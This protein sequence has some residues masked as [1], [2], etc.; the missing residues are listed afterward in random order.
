MLC[1]LSASKLVQDFRLA[2]SAVYTIMILFVECDV[3]TVYHEAIAQ[4]KGCEKRDS[5]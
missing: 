4:V 5:I 3:Y 1:E 2:P